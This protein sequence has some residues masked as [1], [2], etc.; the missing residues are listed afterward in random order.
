MSNKNEIA[1]LIAAGKGE[2]MRPVT[3]ERPK[4]LVSVNGKPM[5]ETVIEGLIGRG[6]KQIYVTV[7]YLGHMFGYLPEKYKNVTIIEN[8][9]YV[10][11][12]NISSVYAAREQMMSGADCFV[13]EA[14]I[15]VSD[16]TIF[17][18]ELTQSC[19]YGKMVAGH[20]D[21]WVFDLDENGRI[22][23]VGKY[24]DD[25]YN[26]CGVCFL[27]AADAKTVAEAVVEAYKHEGEY[28]QK[29]WDEIVDENLDKIDMVVYPVEHSQIVEIDTV[30]E[31]V[32]IDP[33]YADILK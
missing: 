19:Y 13:C 12:N 8:P 23:R 21:D 14:D 1:V 3:S 32:A 10:C 4:P 15:V 2:R 25:V 29:Y 22:V 18:A 24:G 31:L 9:E 7:G 27:K 17:K 6:V 26:M 5:I 16:P 33:S 28:E 30:D 20:S 11:K